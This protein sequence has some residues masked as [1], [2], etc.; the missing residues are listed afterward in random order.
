M[1]YI[2]S[3]SFRFNHGGRAKLQ[4]VT[5]SESL[6][7]ARLQVDH[8]SALQGNQASK[9]N[10]TNQAMQ[11]LLLT[12]SDK[13][14][15]SQTTNSDHKSIT[16]PSRPSLPVDNLMASQEDFSCFRQNRFQNLALLA[17]PHVTCLF[18][19]VPGCPLSVHRPRGLHSAVKQMVQLTAR[20]IGQG[21]TSCQTPV[22]CQLF[23]VLP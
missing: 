9:R 18:R 6:H 1:S 19:A 5:S 7:T 8:L 10:K 17:R 4:Y 2:L 15:H 16:A 13:Q 20:L 22:F 21:C 3:N 23:H 12:Q 11:R 14:T